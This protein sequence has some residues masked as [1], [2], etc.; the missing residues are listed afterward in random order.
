MRKSITRRSPAKNV[1]REDLHF[2]NYP[3]HMK[4]KT[5]QQGYNLSMNLLRKNLQ[6]E[7]KNFPKNITGISS[8]I[9][10]YLDSGELEEI[11][12][13]KCIFTNTTVFLFLVVIN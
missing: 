12:N 10:G 1:S 2:E 6:L 3:Y 9:K 4:I 13:V 5:F 7:M 8:S 11:S